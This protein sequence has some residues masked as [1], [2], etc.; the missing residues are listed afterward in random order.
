MKKRFIYI[1][2]LCAGVFSCKDL[3]LD[4]KGKL[5]EPE[6]YGN[7]FGVKKYFAAIYNGLPIEDFL[8]YGTNSNIAYRPDNYWE[9]GKNSLG[10]MSGEF[11]NTMA[12]VIGRTTAFAM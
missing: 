2:L 3:D 7:E 12:L 8:Y 4:P 9:Q 11:F 5:G 1:T 6:L 10:N